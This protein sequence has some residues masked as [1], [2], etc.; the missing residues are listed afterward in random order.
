MWHVIL[1]LLFFFFLM[2]RRP[3]RSTLFPYT[4]LFRSGPRGPWR[5]PRRV[6]SA[7]YATPLNGLT[8]Q[9]WAPD[10]VQ[11][12]RCCRAPT[13]ASD[14]VGISAST[15]K[16]PLTGTVALSVPSTASVELC[17]VPVRM[18]VFG[19]CVAQRGPP[20][21][22]RA[23]RLGPRRLGNLGS[24]PQLGL[25]WSTGRLHRRPRR[26]HWLCGR[27]RGRIVQCRDDGPGRRC[28]E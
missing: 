27:G 10:E 6:G 2:I 1:L 14:L 24:R 13:P 18:L 23:H 3:P 5:H 16:R 4:T 20:C 17:G 15:R 25:R 22:C 11:P 9:R 26:L 8:R 12:V 21:L 28:D 7:A 19:H